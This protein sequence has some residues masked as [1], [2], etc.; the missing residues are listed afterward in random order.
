M[1]LSEFKLRAIQAFGPDFEHATP[2]NVREFVDSV[3]RDLWNQE[4]AEAAATS[5]CPRPPLDLDTCGAPL[6]YEGSVRQ[7]FVRT[8]ESPGEN[9]ILLL[10]L[11]SLDMAYAGIEQL[12]SDHFNRLFTDD[13]IC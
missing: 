13:S 1:E 8:L 2:A 5:G 7:F 10:W 6:T 11:Y 9:A 12:H 4:K 3:Y